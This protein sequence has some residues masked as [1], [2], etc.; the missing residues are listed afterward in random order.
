MLWLTLLQA[1]L[2]DD[3]AETLVNSTKKGRDQM[4]N[5]IQKR[6]NSNTTSF[7]DGIPRNKVKSFSSVST[8][9]SVK[10]TEEKLITVNAD[11]DLL[12]RPLVAANARQINLREVL[13]YELSP[14]PCSLAHQDGSLR[15]TTKSA[16]CSILEKNVTV[17]P[18]LPVSTSD[19]V[20]I[21]DGMALVQR[22]KSRGGRTFGELSLKYYSTITQASHSKTAMRF[23]SYL[24]STGNDLSRTTNAQDGGHP[25]PSK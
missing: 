2:P 14:V 24:T 19:T 12:G 16:L 10:A 1:V 25:Q 20:N 15:K 13:A 21:I 23:M 17:L 11:R 9:I 8:N 22:M 5:F 18:R 4:N 3:V 6:I 7:W